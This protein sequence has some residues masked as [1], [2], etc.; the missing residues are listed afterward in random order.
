MGQQLLPAEVTGN[1]SLSQPGLCAWS[2]VSCFNFFSRFFLSPHLCS[3]ERGTHIKSWSPSFPA[4]AAQLCLTGSP[5]AGGPRGHG[6]RHTP[7]LALS[8]PSS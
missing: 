4:R 8:A 5:D 6:S 7:W 1:P 3:L 2:L